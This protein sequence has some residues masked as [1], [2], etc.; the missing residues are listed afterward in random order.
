MTIP[1]NLTHK[2]RLI[3]NAIKRITDDPANHDDDNRMAAIKEMV[4]AVGDA[5]NTRR[6]FS[7]AAFNV[8]TG[9]FGW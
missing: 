5:L 9:A 2:E 6:C 1:L 4:V 7:R 8:A 3:A